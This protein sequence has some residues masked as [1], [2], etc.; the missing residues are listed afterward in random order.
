MGDNIEN[1]V[2]GAIGAGLAGILI[3]RGGNRPG[4]VTHVPVL[5]AL[6][7][8]RFVQRRPNSRLQSRMI[9]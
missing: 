1:D 7:E 5:T 4:D 2:R 6:V 3:D 9:G 8:M